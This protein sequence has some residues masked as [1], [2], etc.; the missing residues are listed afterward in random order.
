M[1]GVTGG[2]GFILLQVIP[3][4][5]NVDSFS[6]VDLPLQNMLLSVTVLPLSAKLLRFLNNTKRST[7][8]VLGL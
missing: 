4:A 1:L 6:H 7:W 8:P 2:C 3:G 5:P